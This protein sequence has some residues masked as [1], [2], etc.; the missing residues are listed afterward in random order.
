MA[1]S[2]VILNFISDSIYVRKP[3][4]FS[5]NVSSGSFVYAKRNRLASKV[6]EVSA[7]KGDHA[8]SSISNM[9]SAY[10]N[11]VNGSNN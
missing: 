2:Q 9:G 4:F 6:R 1:V 5:A 10:S 11:S 7:L 8:M 3:R